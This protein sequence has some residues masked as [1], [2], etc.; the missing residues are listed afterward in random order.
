MTL[1]YCVFLINGHSLQCSS[2]HLCSSPELVV[3]MPSDEYAEAASE[4][5]GASAGERPKADARP[6]D[7]SPTRARRRSR[8]RSSTQRTRSHHEFTSRG[9]QSHREGKQVSRREKRQPPPERRSRSSSRRRRIPAR[10]PTTRAR[11][12]SDGRRSS[13]T[14]TRFPARASRRNTQCGSTERTSKPRHDSPPRQQPG[15]DQRPRRRP[16]SDKLNQSADGDQRKPETAASSEV[17]RRRQS[18]TLSGDKP[19]TKEA[20]PADEQRSVTDRELAAQRQA[21]LKQGR[22]VG[23]VPTP[24]TS[25][26]YLVTPHFRCIT[27]PGRYAV[28]GGQDVTFTLELHPE[29]ELL[30]REQIW[31]ARNST[32]PRWPHRSSPAPPSGQHD[33]PLR[34][35][36]RRPLRT[37]MPT[38]DAQY[39]RVDIRLPIYKQACSRCAQR[40]LGKHDVGCTV[41]RGVYNTGLFCIKCMTI[42]ATQDELAKHVALC[43]N[44]KLTEELVLHS[45]FHNG[46]VI[47]P[48]RCT[49]IGCDWR[50]HIFGC[51][52]THTL[53]HRFAI[54]RYGLPQREHFINM[55]S[56]YDWRYRGRN[57]T[58]APPLEIYRMLGCVLR[59]VRESDSRYI[60]QLGMSYNFPPN[61][62][63]EHRTGRETIVS[64]DE[65]LPYLNQFSFKQVKNRTVRDLQHELERRE[66][67][68]QP[69]QSHALRDPASCIASSVSVETVTD[70]AREVAAETKQELVQATS[71]T[72]SSPPPAV[73]QVCQQP[74]TPASRRS[75][76]VRPP[77]GLQLPPATATTTTGRSAAAKTEPR[78]HGGSSG[79]TSSAS[80]TAGS[81]TRI[82]QQETPTP[83]PTAVH[84]LPHSVPLPAQRPQ[85]RPRMPLRIQQPVTPLKQT[86]SPPRSEAPT[87]SDSRSVLSS[88]EHTG[89]DSQSEA[90]T[91]LPS[92]GEQ[93]AAEGQ[94]AR[95]RSKS[96]D[97]EPP[98]DEPVL[99]SASNS[100]RTVTAA[101]D[102]LG[103]SSRRSSRDRRQLTS[104]TESTFILPVGQRLRAWGDQP[105][106]LNQ[107]EIYRR[108]EFSI[109]M[110]L[111]PCTMPTMTGP[112]RHTAELCT[113]KHVCLYGYL[114]PGEARVVFST[115]GEARAFFAPANTALPEEFVDAPTLIWLQSALLGYSMAGTLA[116]DVALG[117]IERPVFNNRHA[118]AVLGD[119][120]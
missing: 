68:I 89:T 52:V 59:Y 55:G 38:Y 63:N 81:D 80:S 1:K 64:F 97:E 71:H 84:R 94:P 2:P 58:M 18:T 28:H 113:I 107:D 22:T 76:E 54:L 77:P 116:V 7:R 110:A 88:L 90:S 62:P 10:P 96:S 60:W 119:C 23:D 93:S 79:S 91:L 16:S 26:R 117:Y 95:K 20:V 37:L 120:D 106:I 53:L 111:A 101:V 45:A 86:Q 31:V 12:S 51:W 104:G 15:G 87:S 103:V 29:V 67:E 6:P 72:T 83:P 82:V 25:A 115:D 8:E 48:H 112:L 21:E 5:E 9:R 100:V 105:T 73:E 44:G 85:C 42:V 19:P 75:P 57:N 11:L 36:L 66:R 99:P 102:Q 65:V 43:Y 109:C 56:W 114:A 69:T 98:G 61:F 78:V 33:T 92:G 47:R 118:L 35:R 34:R 13:S 4:L 70:M 46:D 3:D 32:T 39:E 108:R 14:S 40:A 49:V 30:F 24:P 50:S 27:P 41:S 17:T 74:P